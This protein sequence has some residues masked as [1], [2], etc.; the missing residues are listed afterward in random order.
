MKYAEKKAVENTNPASLN[1]EQAAFYEH[2]ALQRLK[3]LQEPSP[4][5]RWLWQALKA[6]AWL[7]KRPE[8][9]NRE[10]RRPNID[11]ILM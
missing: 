11:R 6:F 4:K 10:L 9:Y 5:T 2:L 7:F 1:Q 8:V 3:E